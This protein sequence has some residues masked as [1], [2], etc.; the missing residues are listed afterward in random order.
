MSASD[1]YDLALRTVRRAHPSAC[2]VLLEV[3]AERL[4]S[5]RSDAVPTSGCS[6]QL[7]D[8]V[9]AES[10][11]LG[12]DDHWVI[13]HGRHDGIDPLE[14]LLESRLD[15]SGLVVGRVRL[16]GAVIALL[17]LHLS[18][19]LQLDRDRDFVDGVAERVSARMDA[20]MDSFW[21][22]VTGKATHPVEVS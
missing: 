21:A 2:T 15:L 10:L 14:T 20:A 18:P 9:A 1:L 13:S 17:V 12:A 11:A 19:G 7:V 4:A 5:C 8:R 3:D 22:S 6:R 16:D